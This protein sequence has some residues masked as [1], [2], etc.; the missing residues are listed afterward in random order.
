MS[1]GLK[2][3]NSIAGSN[4]PLSGFKWWLI[5]SSH[6]HWSTISPI[7]MCVQECKWIIVRSELRF[8][9]QTSAADQS[10][11]NI[12]FKIFE[13]EFSHNYIC[14]SPLSLSP[15]PAPLLMTREIIKQV[16]R[17][18][19]IAQVWLEPFPNGPVNRNLAAEKKLQDMKWAKIDQYQ[20]LNV[21]AIISQT[22]EILHFLTPQKSVRDL[23]D[24]PWNFLSD[25]LVTVL[26]W[27]SV[28]KAIYGVVNQ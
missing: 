25:P 4:C 5:E 22:K 10:P 17:D 23:T 6:C 24:S 9:P 1:S 26:T 14:L 2:A 12:E 28:N 11:K 18:L 16:H 8:R 3:I 19:F 13:I 15:H 20:D 21:R 7:H 27:V